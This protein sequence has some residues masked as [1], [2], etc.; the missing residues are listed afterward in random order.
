MFM[1]VIYERLFMGFL[2][3]KKTRQTRPAFKKSQKKLKNNQ[4]AAGSNACRHAC[5]PLILY[6]G[7]DKRVDTPLTCFSNIT[8]QLE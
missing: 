5:D 6:Q 2:L 7:V 3:A 1:Q 8:T 4:I